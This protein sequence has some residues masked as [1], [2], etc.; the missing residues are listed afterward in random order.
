MS[1][2]NEEIADQEE[3]S[4]HNNN[5]LLN[6]KNSIELEI[7]KKPSSAVRRIKAKS[8]PSKNRFNQLKP[9]TAVPIEF[10][11]PSKEFH[12]TGY[13]IEQVPNSSI[14][15][16]IVDS[17]P[18]LY[19]RLKNLF[20]RGMVIKQN[21]DLSFS[22]LELTQILAAN[23]QYDY[24]IKPKRKQGYIADIVQFLTQQSHQLVSPT[25]LTR[26]YHEQVKLDKAERDNELAA[27]NQAPSTEITYDDL[28]DRWL[29][30]TQDHHR[31]SFNFS[32]Y[33]MQ[34]KFTDDELVIIAENNGIDKKGH[35]ANKTRSQLV[36]EITKLIDSKQ[37][38]G[39][40]E[41]AAERLSKKLDEYNNIEMSEEEFEEE[42]ETRSAAGPPQPSRRKSAPVRNSNNSSVASTPN[43]TNA[44]YKRRIAHN[45]HN[46]AGNKRS[47][48]SS[49]KSAASA[50]ANGRNHFNRTNSHD[51]TSTQHSQTST[52]NNSTAASQFEQPSASAESSDER[53]VKLQVLGCG[54]SKYYSVPIHKK[55]KFLNLKVSSMDQFKNAK[56]KLSLNGHELLPQETCGSMGI[57]NNSIIT[58]DFAD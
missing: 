31:T 53:K 49:A 55:F 12:H 48:V 5:N 50:A 32:D 52:A 4:E 45:N 47:R 9:E 46:S 11:D 43:S 30:I 39:L 18:V 56:I 14:T 33:S 17:Y 16:D 22:H 40:K 41:A 2:L 7:E 24:N 28:V 6:N 42:E 38:K 44:S 13:A 54:V 15:Q 35:R 29:D 37:L 51:S 36:A 26:K 8:D 58:I 21:I 1:S 34:Y 20:D 27:A 3:E 23:S 57:T 25:E 10:I 19:E